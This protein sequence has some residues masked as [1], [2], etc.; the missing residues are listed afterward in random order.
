MWY[1][2]TLLTY[3]TF[4]TE[5]WAYFFVCMLVSVVINFIKFLWPIQIKKK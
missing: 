3:K 5:L 1:T 2:L 4:L